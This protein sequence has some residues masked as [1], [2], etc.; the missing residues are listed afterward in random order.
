MTT[1]IKHCLDDLM[2]QVHQE[3]TAQSPEDPRYVRAMMK[4]IR[5]AI[6]TTQEL[7]IL[8]AVYDT[9]YDDADEDNGLYNI[10]I[11]ALPTFYL[12]IDLELAEAIRTAKLW[13]RSYTLHDYMFHN[14]TITRH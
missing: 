12:F 8:P 14:H 3:L 2:D 4:E 6:E 9:Y 13:G 11:P 10:I 5:H 1:Q 7:W